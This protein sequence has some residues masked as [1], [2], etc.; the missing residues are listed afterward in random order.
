M[1][2][3]NRHFL[4]TYFFVNP[5][6]LPYRSY[7]ISQKLVDKPSIISYFPSIFCPILGHHQGMMYYKSDVTFVCTLLLCKNEL[8]YCCIVYHLLTSEDVYLMSICISTLKV[9]EHYMSMKLDF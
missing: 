7:D 5:F 3:N 6:K 2:E 8:L 1:I 4:S 9:Y